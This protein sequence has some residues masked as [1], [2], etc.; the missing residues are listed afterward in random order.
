M[1]S[2][3]QTDAVVIGAGLAG[4][5]VA[6]RLA[7]D[8]E[9]TVVRPGRA[10]PASYVARGGIAAAIGEDDA[11]EL[12]AA[13]TVEA[14]GA[15][16]DEEI[17]QVVAQEGLDRVVELFELSVGFDRDESGRLQLGREAMHR[18]DRIVHVDGDVTGR[19]VTSAVREQLEDR[20]TVYFVDGRVVELIVDERRVCG[21]VFVG[22][23]GSVGAVVAP[24]VVLATG[25]IGGLYEKT[26]NPEGARG[27]GVALAARAGATLVDLEFV[28][29]HPTALAG[30]GRP[31]PLLS[32]ALRGQGATLIDGRGKRLMEDHPGGDLAGR[33]AV[34]RRLWRHIRQG[35]RAYLDCTG[36]EAFE[37]RFPAA[38]AACRHR[39]LEPADEPVPVVPAAH[40]HMG[41]VATDVD[42]RTDRPGLWAVGEVA[43]T[44]VHGANRLASN[45]LLEAMVFG[46]RAARSIA[47]EEPGPS[48]VDVER[49]TEARRLWRRGV[50]EGGQAR[51]VY[52]RIRRRMWNDVG[53][54]RCRKGLKRAGRQFDE[55]VVEFR[56]HDPVRLA[57]ESARA[58]TRAAQRRTESRG[59]HYRSDVPEPDPDFG[60]RLFVE[61]AEAGLD[62]ETPCCDFADWVAVAMEDR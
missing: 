11:P 8:R 20:E 62:P 44:G 38:G 28:Q 43:S 37:K 57:V 49:I 15:L 19:H 1:S 2:I 23:D 61:G 42:G 6:E 33:D 24:A 16:V 5:T 50:V 55:M 58:V 52:R 4:L 21:V 40:Y 7:A 34:A 39:G 27:E 51:E 32:E 41:G 56:Y 9:V 45:S 13:D 60:H 30:E 17:A 59:A 29:F 26:T 36:I 46:A 53:I 54:C 35:G 14:G 10:N 31:L 25:G 47:R 12:H 18:R 48:P 3:I 22:S